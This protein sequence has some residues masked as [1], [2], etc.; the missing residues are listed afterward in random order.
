MQIADIPIDHQ[1][2]ASLALA[3]P[4]M[5]MLRDDKRLF[6]KA[7]EWINKSSG[8]GSLTL[9]THDVDGKEEVVEEWPFVMFPGSIYVEVFPNLF[10]WADISVDEEL[11]EQYDRDAYDEECGI[12]DSEDGR[13][14][15]YTEEYD[16]WHSG[17]AQ[18]RPYTVDSGEVAL[19]QL[20]LRLN[21]TGKA[22]LALEKYLTE[23]R[24]T[25]SSGRIGQDY[26]LGLKSLVRKY[27][28]DAETSD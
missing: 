14:I 17:M 18:I 4:W 7:E 27:G 22:Y 24:P 9:F 3:K 25:K 6:L 26:G 2:L 16:E 23:G 12:W 15:M 13:Y 20:E 10:P 28:L 11:Y 19:F 8:R 1:R 21:E 5:E